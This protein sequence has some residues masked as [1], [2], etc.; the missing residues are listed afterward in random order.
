MVPSHRLPEGGVTKS[1]GRTT[2]AKPTVIKPAVHGRQYHNPDPIVQLIGEANEATVLI[3]TYIHIYTHTY[4]H[5][6]IQTYIHTCMHIHMH[7][8]K[9]T[10]LPTNI[11]DFTFL[12]F[13]ISGIS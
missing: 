9:H 10:C 13:F 4:I 7:T 11:H 5:T 3:D 2:L 1:P 8:Y 12:D 6:Y